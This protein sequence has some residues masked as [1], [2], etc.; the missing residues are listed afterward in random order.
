[1]I[2]FLITTLLVSAAFHLNYGRVFT[3]GADKSSEDILRG[4]HFKIH[5]FQVNFNYNNNE[6]I[7][8]LSF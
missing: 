3:N 8:Q 7:I 2:N 1:M 5:A 6:K 4:I